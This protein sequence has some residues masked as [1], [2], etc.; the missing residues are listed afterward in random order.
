[1]SLWAVSARVARMQGYPE[2]AIW[3]DLPTFYLDDAVQGFVTLEGA[4]K[5]A[6]DVIDPHGDA[7]D[8]SITVVPA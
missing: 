2:D 8:M 5:V 3:H 1:M 4:L 6:E 7:V